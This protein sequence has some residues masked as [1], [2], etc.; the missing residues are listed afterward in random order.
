MYTGQNLQAF[1]IGRQI[2]VAFLIFIVA[3]IAG[4]D[5]E[6][7]E[8]IFGVSGSLQSFFNT[9]LLGAVILTIIGSLVWRIIA[10]SFPLV[11]MSNPFIY[12]VIRICLLLETTGICSAS[13]IFAKF[14]KHIF[15]YQPDEVYI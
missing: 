3:R 15:N 8:N 4:I 6:G 2:F 11:F 7:T 12:I 14:L 13:W 5:M 9:G 10:S 1:L